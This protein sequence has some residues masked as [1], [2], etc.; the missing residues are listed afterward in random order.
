MVFFFFFKRIS[1]WRTFQIHPIMAC[2]ENTPLVRN[3]R[4]WCGVRVL[5]FFT[6]HVLQSTSWRAD[7]LQPC[8]LRFR[9]T[10]MYVMYSTYVPQQNLITP[11]HGTSS[12]VSSST[13]EYVH[14]H[15]YVCMY[16]CIYVCACSHYYST[17]DFRI[18]KNPSRFA[19]IA[20]I[21]PA[22]GVAA[23]ASFGMI[24]GD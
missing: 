4:D 19:P 21:P 2:S 9:R 15:M 10:C 14:A 18:T 24:C 20:I 22:H 3:D 7:R 12:L 23:C 8:K 6:L 5:I 17:A 13:V 11:N 1:S 16:V